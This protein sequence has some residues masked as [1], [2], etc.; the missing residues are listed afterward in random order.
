MLLFKF[1]FIWANLILF[2]FFY[3]EIDAH[4]LHDIKNILFF[5]AIGRCLFFSGV[6]MKVE[7]IDFV[8]DPC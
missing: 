8:E 2:C 1:L 6:A 5:T 3:E 7:D 4:T